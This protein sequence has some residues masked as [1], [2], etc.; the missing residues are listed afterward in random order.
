MAMHKVTA[1]ETVT[2]NHGNVDL[3]ARL[4]LGNAVVMT[5]VETTIRVEARHHRGLAVAMTTMEATTKAVDMVA[6]RVV[7]HPVAELRLGS[8]R[9]IHP[10]H[11][12]LAIST[13]MAAIQVDMAV[14]VT[15]VSRAWVHLQ[16]CPPQADLAL[17]LDL[18]LSSRTMAQMVVVVHHLRHLLTMHLLQ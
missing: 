14:E 12:H 1:E 9:T 18:E 3:P 5:E 6:L 17:L 7:D 4:L 16:E 11:L 8:D 15:V 10:L 2:P 13:V